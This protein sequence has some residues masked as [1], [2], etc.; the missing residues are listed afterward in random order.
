MEFTRTPSG[1]VEKWR[2]YQEPTVWLEGPTDLFFYE[3]ISNGLS[4]RFE[5]FHGTQNAKALIKALKEHSYPYLVILDGDYSVLKRTRSPHNQVIILQR[6]SYENFLWESEAINKVCL[7]HARC[8]DQK[9]LVI[10]AMSQAVQYLNNELLPLLIL[11]VAAR[12]MKTSLKVLPDKIE[13]LL[14]DQTGFRFDSA[15]LKAAINKAE[16][17]VDINCLREARDDVSSS[18]KQKCIT[19][20]V[21]GHLVFGLLRR[22]FVHAANRERGSKLVTPD[23][24]LLQ[25]FSEAIWRYC[26]ESDHKRLK[27]SFRSKLLKLSTSRHFFN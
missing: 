1:L 12:R 19:H 10:S 26:K 25:K 5:P 13:R 18:L 3:P 8:G 16:K 4:C 15:R 23:D 6:Y 22:I 20:L 24:D 21:N 17:E 14:A 11:D 9:D 27:R 2:F 7:R